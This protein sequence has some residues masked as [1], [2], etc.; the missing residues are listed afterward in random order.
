MV[1]A[2]EVKDGMALRL[3]EKLYKVLEV[4]RH[5]GAGQM[6][7]FIELKLKD[8]RFGHFANKHV[9]TSDRLETVDLAKRQMDYIYAD[10]EACY[11]MDPDSFEQVGIPRSAVG[12]LEKFMKE[13]MK[14]TVQLL[15]GEAVS[16]QFA[17][18]VE[19]SIASA[20]PGVHGQGENTM[21][22]ATLENGLE[23]LVPHFVQTGDVVRV[24]TDKVKYI[25]RVTSRRV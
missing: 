11:F 9:K 6:H 8:V 18:V 17:K 10:Q 3:D 1:L 19:L 22:P 2:T 16:V 13:G 20:G 14:V 21:K 4:V 7:G 12:H 25:D 23:I 24:D 15:G 5:A